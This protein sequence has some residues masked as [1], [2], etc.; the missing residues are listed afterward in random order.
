[1]NN[2]LYAILV[3]GALGAVFGFVLAYASKVFAVKVDERQEEILSVL[4]GANCGGCGFPGCSGY[5]AAV[6]E[7]RAA[8][9]LCVAGGAACTAK[10]S[11]IMGTES[12]STEK[13]VAFVRC[14]G[15]NNSVKKYDFA[16]V[17]DCLSASLL[18][19]KGPAECTFACLGL[20]SCVSACRF[21]AIHVIDGAAVV[22]K[23]KCVGCMAC[24]Q[25]CPKNLI[26]KVPYSAKVTIPCSSKE[27]GPVTNKMCSVGCIACK[28]CE[29]ACPN[30][31]VHV[32]DNLAVIDYSKCDGCGACAQK[33]PRKLIKLSDTVK[34]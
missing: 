3:L 31:A 14:S 21:D 13:C 9:N 8:T 10:I 26:A 11:A 20:G 34:N 1:M 7:G 2:V 4:P 22:D 12:G 32:V 30:D 23:E 17:S 5:A 29:K 33:C 28:L 18:P 6:V 16:G 19:G 24:A 25:K 15:I 27:K